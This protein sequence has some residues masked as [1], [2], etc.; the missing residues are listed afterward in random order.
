MEPTSGLD[1][2]RGFKS[3]GA[4]VQY[5]SSLC[6]MFSPAIVGKGPVPNSGWMVADRWAG[7]DMAPCGNKKTMQP[8]D[9]PLQGLCMGEY[10]TDINKVGC[11]PRSLVHP[12]YV[13]C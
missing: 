3:L 12:E 7:L 1:W 9:G 11:L 4:W 10:D 6:S 13:R 2:L 8:Q 5:L